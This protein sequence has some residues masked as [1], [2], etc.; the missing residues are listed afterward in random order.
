MN[1]LFS[2]K[3]VINI[4]SLNESGRV[5]PAIVNA[6]TEARMSRYTRRTVTRGAIVCLA[7]ALGALPLLIAS[8]ALHAQAPALA[9]VGSLMCSF[10]VSVSATWK[11][12]EPDAQVKHTGILSFR[13]DDINTQEGSALFIAGSPGGNPEEQVVAQLAGSN[14]HFVDIR[15]D[16]T[17]AVTTVF[18]QASRGRKLKAVYTR[19]KYEQ[20]SLP[21]DLAEPEITQRYGDCEVAE[22]RK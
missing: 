21:Y 22:P 17:L 2:I 18:A 19:T 9:S 15:S 4:S 11:N 10:P 12:G 14:L 20:F 1:H 8:R 13:L 16:G 7:M 5:S 6:A 3:S